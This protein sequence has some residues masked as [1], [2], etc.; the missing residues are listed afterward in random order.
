MS[1]KLQK[2]SEKRQKQQYSADSLYLSVTRHLARDFQTMLDDPTLYQDVI[3]AS[4]AK[5]IGG[6]RAVKPVPCFTDSALKFK[7]DYQIASIDKR[8]RYRNDIYTDDE[9]QELAINKFLDVQNRLSALNWEELLQDERMQRILRL[10]RRLCRKILGTCDDERI[11]QSAAFGSGASVGVAAREAHLA[12]RYCIPITGTKH[13]ISWWRSEYDQCPHFQQWLCDRYGITDMSDSR[14]YKEIDTLA[15][16][17]VPKSHKSLRAILPNTTIGS[18]QSGGIGEYIR[19]RLMKS[20]K[21]DVRKLQ[22]QHRDTARVASTDQRHLT[23]DLQSASDSISGELLEILLPD[24]WWKLLSENRAEF[25]SLPN[26]TKIQSNTFCTM[27][28]GYTFTLQTL[29]FYAL[30]WAC[31]AVSDRFLRPTL[32][33]V[34]GDDLIFGSHLNELVRDVFGRVGIVVNE[35]KTFTDVPFRESC[36]GDYFHGR[37]VRPFQPELALNVV[38]VHMYEAC[39]YKF[40][41]GLLA[42]WDETQIPGTLSYLTGEI[43]KVALACK[44]VPLSYPEDSGIRTAKTAGCS[45]ARYWDFLQYSRVVAPVHVGHGRYRFVFL[46]K[47]LLEKEELRH[48]PYYWSALRDR[49][50]VRDSYCDTGSRVPPSPIDLSF[51]VKS[52][53]SIIH[54]SYETREVEP[55]L[56]LKKRNTGT[57][58]VGKDRPAKGLP[59]NASP[60]SKEE[61]ITVVG[62]SHTG[63]YRRKKG[64]S[65]FDD[66]S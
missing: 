50:L 34:Y 25:I 45:A 42:R 49:S 57:S 39:L 7:A 3:L 31:Q 35:D 29:V 41:N 33:S 37:D 16:T 44:L 60:G 65:C 51:H 52:L 10:A 28:V 48:G 64:T 56:L 32:I 59:N 11:R 15:L 14:I 22:H 20:V 26:G 46:K 58:K 27:G 13:Q 18:Y 63:I 21:L 8:Y 38:H 5:D 61:R 2:R 66:Q 53:A 30:I 55:L 6:L 9:L 1:G 40:V 36:G 23:M 62:I 47:E 24:D 43:E 4:L 19:E 12:Q 54:G 17:F